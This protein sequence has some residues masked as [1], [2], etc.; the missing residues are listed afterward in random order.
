MTRK[1]S[2][3]K[4]NQS[5]REKK[6]LEISQGNWREYLNKEFSKS[7]EIIKDYSNIS[8]SEDILRTQ[9]SFLMSLYDYLI[10]EVLKYKMLDIFDGNN[11]DGIKGFNKFKISMSNL[12][13]AI[14]HPKNKKWLENEI[15]SQK[16]G[17][18]FINP[19]KTLEALSIVS[20]ENILGKYCM[21]NKKDYNQFIE[22]LSTLNK[23]R[24]KI[25]HEMDI[26]DKN[27]WKRQE[28]KKK[29]VDDYV[30]LIEDLGNY[31]INKI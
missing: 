9:L 22:E 4:R 29:E 14:E 2:E 19:N 15:E 16:G 5:N 13:I 11:A 10:H 27:T 17:A 23:R 30:K 21:D 6:P 28:I 26:I 31:I 1:F 8:E 12:R 7:I 18:S 3:P 20:S 24:N 25:V